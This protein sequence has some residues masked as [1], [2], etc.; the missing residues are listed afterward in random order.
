MACAVIAMQRKH[1]VRT[2]RQNEACCLLHLRC[3]FAY[4]MFLLI[5]VPTYVLARVLTSGAS[6]RLL[7]C[8]RPVPQILT[9]H[10][11][12]THRLSPAKTAACAE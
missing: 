1:L 4:E 2:L 8:A 6:V 10:S 3:E 11:D 12:A 9:S 5:S 7:L